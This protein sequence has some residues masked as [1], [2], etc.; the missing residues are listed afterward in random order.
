MNT[1]T[2][3]LWDSRPD[4]TEAIITQKATGTHPFNTLRS[5]FSAV[6]CDRVGKSE[7]PSINDTKKKLSH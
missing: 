3:K 7:L 2:G 1:F 4:I 6:V 5:Y